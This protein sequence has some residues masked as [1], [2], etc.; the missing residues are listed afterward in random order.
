MSLLQLRECLCHWTERQG[1]VSLKV[2]PGSLLLSESDSS[3]SVSHWVLYL[4][5]G[6]SYS[7]G[8]RWFTLISWGDKEVCPSLNGLFSGHTIVKPFLCVWVG[9]DLPSYCCTTLLRLLLEIFSLH[10]SLLVFHA[11]QK[12]LKSVVNGPC[13][14][15]SALNLMLSSWRVRNGN[16]SLR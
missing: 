15:W 8:F 1:K 11:L 2:K 12:I 7:L 3:L 9:R 5:S 16:R 13:F 4:S 6:I 14:I 10:N